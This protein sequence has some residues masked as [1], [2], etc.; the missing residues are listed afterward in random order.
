[1]KMKANRKRSSHLRD[2]F[3]EISRFSGRDKKMYGDL[4]RPITTAVTRDF[5]SGGPEFSWGLSIICLSK[6]A[7]R[8]L[9]RIDE[10]WGA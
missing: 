1:M 6:K 7:Q 5:P 3:L 4:L 10:N 8:K 2:V 9:E